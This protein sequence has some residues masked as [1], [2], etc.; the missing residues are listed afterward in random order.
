MG[1]AVPASAIDQQQCGAWVADG[2]S[3][4]PGLR[5]WLGQLYRLSGIETRYSCIPGADT[6]A[7]G[8]PFRPGRSSDEVPS[9]AQRMALYQAASVDIASQ[10]ARRA[11]ADRPPDAPEPEITHLLVTSCTGF[12][13]PGLDLALARA[14][15]LSPRVER[16][17]IGF[18]GCAA[19]FNALRLAKHI[20]AG[21]AD[22]KVLVVCV[23][24]CTIHLPPGE[25]RPSLIVGSLFADGAA[26]CVVEATDRSSQDA[27]V[28]DAFTTGVV[29]DSAGDMS[30]R[31]GDQGF[32]MGI[33]SDVPRR[34]GG[35]ATEAIHS[36]FDLGEQPQFWAIHPGGRAIVDR[37]VD[38]FQ[39]A[40]QAVAPSYDVLRN[41][42]NMSSPT[43]LFVL[44]RMRRQLRRATVGE[45]GVAMAFGPGLVAEAAR[46]RYVPSPERMELYPASVVPAHA[47]A[48]S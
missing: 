29:P 46:V 39:I 37:L 34:I 6:L 38:L 15:N 11:L 48:I 22:A 24:L 41:Y 2:V 25:E 43:I 44:D 8:S 10:A 35:I 47:G 33:S 16:T 31:I 12:F 1:T 21:Q 42:G 7:A 18:M 17:L 14:L 9:T 28:L 26:A 40:P 13:A 4:S 19:A 23:E 36:L 5:R 27:L 20:V 45:L 30:W 3:A 32:V